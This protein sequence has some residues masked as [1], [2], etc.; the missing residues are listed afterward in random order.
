M[1]RLVNNLTRVLL[2]TAVLM[3]SVSSVAQT[4]TVGSLEATI[5]GQP[6]IFHAIHSDVDANHTAIWM[7]RDGEQRIAMLGGYESLDVEFTDSKVSGEGAML[8]I[9]FGYSALQ[10][11][12]SYLIPSA[13]GVPVN[14]LLMSRVG[15]HA[16]S[17]MVGQG[18]LEVT[19]IQQL[20]DGTTMFK[21]T[22][23]GSLEDPEETGAD[24][25]ITEGLFE[26]KAR[27][28]APR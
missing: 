5:A 9:S 13:D 14:I 22:F 4:R 26:L 16:S 2:G 12:A 18:Q 21:G 27:Q 24:N 17:R 7:A 11:E 25:M 10:S 20:A 8:V 1:N 15:D 28:L 23:N 19:Q 6:M 3:T